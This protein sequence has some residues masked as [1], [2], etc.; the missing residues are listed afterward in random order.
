M[1]F[2]CIELWSLLILKRFPIIFLSDYS[3]AL[4]TALCHEK[5]ILKVFYIFSKIKTNYLKQNYT[6]DK[7]N[8]HFVYITNTVCMH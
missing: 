4:L 3:F 8:Y 6:D 1:Q 7:D 5:N 2:Q